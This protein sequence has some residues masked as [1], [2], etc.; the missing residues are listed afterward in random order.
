MDPLMFSREPGGLVVMIAHVSPVPG[1]GLL[2]QSCSSLHTHRHSLFHTLSG[3]IIFTLCTHTRTDKLPHTHTAWNLRPLPLSICRGYLCNASFRP[4]LWLIS[5]C[6]THLENM[7]AW[8]CVLGDK[9][10]ISGLHATPGSS[11]QRHRHRNVQGESMGQTNIWIEQ[12][13]AKIQPI[14]FIP[15]ENWLQ[16]HD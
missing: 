13:I 14:Q 6:H 3:Y 4:R 2:F 1:H 10:V 8:L 7:A 15:C 12:K 9:A 16:C 5:S 11:A